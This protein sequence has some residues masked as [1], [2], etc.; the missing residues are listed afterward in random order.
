MRMPRDAGSFAAIGLWILACGGGSSPK[1]PTPATSPTPASAAR[2]LARAPLHAARVNTTTLAYR[3]VG[4]S[5]APVIVFVHGSLGDIGDWDAQVAPFAQHYRVLTYS[6]RYHP[7]NPIVNDTQAY[8]PKL[9]AE[10]LAALLLSLDLAPAHVVG[11]SYGA[12][13]AL[14]LALEHPEL[15]RSLVL[16]EPPIMPLLT[17]TPP[18][19]SVRRAFFMN[20]LDPARRAFTAGDSVAGVRLFV[21]GDNGIRRF[22]N[23]STAARADMLAH[24]FELRREMLTSREA[25]LPPVSCPDLS[26]L[27]TPVLLLTG[28][29]SSRVFRMITDE[30]ARCLNGDTTIVIPGAGHAMHSANPAYYN[31]TVFRFLVTH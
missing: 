25:Y 14:E 29:R 31:Q 8:S 5:G 15:V 19:D 28:E 9:H 7:P 22:D 20:T 12:Y 27:R 23:L 3:L 11:A 2:N 1:A 21:D 10:D 16:A 4:D 17:R 24:A 13:T 18:G 26:R 6:R 30:L